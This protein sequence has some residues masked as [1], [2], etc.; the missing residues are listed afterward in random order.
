MI[1]QTVTVDPDEKGHSVSPLVFDFSSKYSLYRKCRR[2]F[3]VSFFFFFF[4]G[5]GGEGGGLRFTSEG[6]LTDVAVYANFRNTWHPGY[7]TFFMLN[8][9]E[10]EIYPAH[11]MTSRNKQYGRDFKI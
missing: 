2:N 5:G 8:S 3:V 9:A 4:L 6:Y 1:L 7:K 11:T 10:H